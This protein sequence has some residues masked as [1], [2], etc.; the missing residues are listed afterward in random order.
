MVDLQYPVSFRYTAQQFSY[1]YT[2][3][4]IY[5]YI[6]THVFFF[7]FSSLVGYY[8]ILSI[9]IPKVIICIYYPQV[10]K[11]IPLPPPLPW[12]PQ[13]YSLSWWFSFLSFCV[14]LETISSHLWWSMIMREKRIYTCMCN[15]VTMLCSGKLTEHCK[16]A[17]MKK[18]KIVT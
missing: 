4:C 6:C 3:I 12:Q 8:K 15:W 1:T 13:V 10:P 17:I 11:S 16:P 7:I 2:Y 18:I 5:S 9:S 14:A